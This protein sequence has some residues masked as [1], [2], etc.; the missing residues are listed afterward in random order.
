VDVQYVEQFASAV[1]PITRTENPIPVPTKSSTIKYQY[2]YEK[3][4][5]ELTNIV[6]DRVITAVYTESLR[7]YSAQYVSKGVVVQPAESGKGH[8]GDNIVYTG[9][10]PTYTAEEPYVF[11]LFN[12]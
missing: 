11:H 10:T 5:T 9:N 3:W 2:T 1:N 12:R 6:S 7:E 4:D 8:Y